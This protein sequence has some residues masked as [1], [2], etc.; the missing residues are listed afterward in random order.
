ME[1][2]IA[3]GTR[4]VNRSVIPGLD[5][6]AGIIRPAEPRDFPAL[7]DIEDKAHHYPWPDA[8][9]HWAITQK[10]SFTRVLELQQ[11]I[12]GFAIFECVLDE[13]SLLNIA[14][15]PDWQKR[16][17]GRQLLETCIAELGGKATRVLLEVRA[18][19][20]NAL[21]LYLSMGFA[22]I[23]IRKDYYPTFTGREHAHM[24]ELTLP[25]K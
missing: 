3:I 1:K 16:G 6:F 12:I 17:I 10:C 5:A 18:S 4:G 19:N 25:V 14:I 7:I 11:T 23:G 9:L 2:I 20:H 22:E 21:R 24:M 15:D 13:A 8:T